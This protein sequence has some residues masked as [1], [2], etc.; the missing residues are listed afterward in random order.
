MYGLV[1][2]GGGA[3][4]AY[5]IG[6]CKALQEL[7][8]QIG[9]VTGTSVGALNAAMITQGDIDKAYHMWE[10]I[11]PAKILAVDEERL[12]ELRQQHLNTSNISYYLKRFRKILGE[13]GLDV[14]P[15]RTLLQENVNE[16]KVRQSA[17]DMGIV[18]VSISDFKPLELFVKDIPEGQLIDYLM[19]SAGFPAFKPE[20]MNGKR[21]IDGGFHDNLPVNMMISRGFTDIIVIRTFGPGR[22]R[23]IIKKGLHIR[24]ISPVEDLGGILDF[25]RDLAKKNLQM[26]YFDALKLFQGLQGNKYY[27]DLHFDEGF[28][29]QKLIN[30]PEKKILY[31]GKLLGFK[32]GPYRR[33]L[34]EQIVPLLAELLKLDPKANYAEFSILFLEE[35]A[36]RCQVD[37]FKIYTLAEFLAAIKARYIPSRSKVRPE[38]PDLLKRSRLAPLL[39]REEIFDEVACQLFEEIL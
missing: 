19:A 23:K 39:A 7:E 38:L 32:G 29:L 13:G 24:T 37:R 22:R 33:M 36:N 31:I 20:L 9:A 27:I 8:L 25:D 6:A 12:L 14:T 11:S 35:I 1:L 3:R 5:Q 30:L 26:G 16:A 21:F 15:L 17:I 34:F 4:G 28:F 18:T 2:E 10:N